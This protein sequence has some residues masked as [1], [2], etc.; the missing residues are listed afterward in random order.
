MS[1]NLSD[2]LYSPDITFVSGSYSCWKSFYFA[3]IVFA[4]LAFGSGLACLLTRVIPRSAWTHAW[5]GRA[6]IIFMLWTTATSILIH[7][8]GLPDGTLISF[9]WVLGGLTIGW[10]VVVVYQGQMQRKAVLLAE[11]QTKFQEAGGDWNK[12]ISAA[13]KEI[14]AGKSFRERILSL[15]AFHGAMMFMSWM[16]IAGRVFATPNINDFTCYT[17]PYYKPI[18]TPVF[19]GAGQPITPVPAYTPAAGAAP[20]NIM[21]LTNWSILMS[22]GP[23]LVAYAVGVIYSY[24]A[25]RR[26]TK[27]A[28]KLD[29]MDGQVITV[30][31][32]PLASV[33]AQETGSE[34]NAH[35]P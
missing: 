8:N 11:S 24:I 4:Y 10:V 35:G 28:A 7:N 20:W 18:D 19:Q 16:N 14:A 9:L 34:R 17:Y 6:Y 3:H 1:Y 25:A 26:G 32:G 22:I 15:K 29:M 33:D 2:T 5:F 30:T 27:P 31:A 21:G 13:K 12:L 23:L